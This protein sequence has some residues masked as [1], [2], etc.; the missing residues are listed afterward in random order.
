MYSHASLQLAKLAS[1][2]LGKGSPQETAI[3]V[4][5]ALLASV[6]MLA[7]DNDD[8]ALGMLNGEDFEVMGTV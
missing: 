3:S 5:V 4:S 2:G 6:V 1:P 8:F 7:K